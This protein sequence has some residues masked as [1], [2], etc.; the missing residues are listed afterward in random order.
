MT[1]AKVCLRLDMPDMEH[2]GVT[3]VATEASAGRSWQHG[4]MSASTFRLLAAVVWVAGTRLA[5]YVDELSFSR[6]PSFPKS[7]SSEA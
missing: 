5:R 1:G 4:T 7:W 6:T 3:T 2:R